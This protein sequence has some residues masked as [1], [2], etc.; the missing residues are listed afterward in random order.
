MTNLG[1]NP[2]VSEEQFNAAMA[3]RR[4]APIPQLIS[5]EEYDTVKEA[6]ADCAYSTSGDLSR[7]SCNLLATLR[8]RERA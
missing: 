5:L 3:A 1:S 7:R 2:I 6:L 4:A 8:V